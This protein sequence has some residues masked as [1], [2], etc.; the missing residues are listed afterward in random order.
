MIHPDRNFPKVKLGEFDRRPAVV[1]TDRTGEPFLWSV[2]K[3]HREALRN[4]I[5]FCDAALAER[6]AGLNV[7][8]A[9]EP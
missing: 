8:T 7:P 1:I 2:G 3:T 9:E 5:A 6:A 4:G